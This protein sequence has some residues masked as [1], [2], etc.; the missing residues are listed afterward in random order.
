M[1]RDNAPSYVDRLGL[2]QTHQTDYR[3]SDI[4]AS[5]SQ[6]VI[7]PAVNE[8]ACLLFDIVSIFEHAEGRAASVPQKRSIYFEAVRQGVMRATCFVLDHEDLGNRVV[9]RIL[10]S[11]NRLVYVGIDQL[12]RIGDRPPGYYAVGDQEYRGRVNAR[13]E[14]CAVRDAAGHFRHIGLG[15]ELLH[16]SMPGLDLTHVMSYRLYRIGRPE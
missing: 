16:D 11:D 14:Q 13:L 2:A 6:G 5:D 15:G 8:W 9:A 3:Y 12:V 7:R 4:T 10:G 1:I